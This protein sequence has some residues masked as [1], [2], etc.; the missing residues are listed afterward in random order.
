MGR[1]PVGTTH[2]KCQGFNVL[3][4]IDGDRI[5]KQHSEILK[6]E[7]FIHSTQAADIEVEFPAGMPLKKVI[8]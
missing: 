8:E 4:A 6:Q 3:T 1:A 7:R 5:V 2:K